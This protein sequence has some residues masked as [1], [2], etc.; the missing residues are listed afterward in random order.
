MASKFMVKKD[1]VV[2]EIDYI[3]A[4]DE[5]VIITSESLKKQCRGKLKTLKAKFVRPNNKLFNLCVNGC[6]RMNEYGENYLDRNLFNE[7][8]FRLL[9]IEAVDGDG[10]KI[11]NNSNQID[12]LMQELTTA[13][14]EAF[15]QK[16]EEE[17]RQA[18]IKVGVLDEEGNLISEKKDEQDQRTKVVE[19]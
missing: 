3:E 11:Q 17:K 4:G 9:F 12:S 13:L 7:K 6:I 19:D 5:I 8:R 1:P 10:E 2:V 16:L 18:L 15:D 14:I